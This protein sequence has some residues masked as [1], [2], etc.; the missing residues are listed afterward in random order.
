M[1]FFKPIAAF[2]AKVQW[3]F[4]FY[5][6]ESEFIT[7][8]YSMNAKDLTS[9]VLRSIQPLQFNGTAEELDNGLVAAM[10]APAVKNLELIHNLQTHQASVE[11]AK[12]TAE[13]EKEKSKGTTVSTGPT[14]KHV[15]KDPRAK[16][17]QA[18][19]DKVRELKNQKK[20][21]QA[22]AQLPKIADYPEKKAEITALANELRA[23]RGDMDLFDQASPGEVL[24]PEVTKMAT[25]LAP[26]EEDEDPGD[27]G[28]D[29]DPGSTEGSEESDE[30]EV[31]GEYDEEHSRAPSQLEMLEK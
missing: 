16:K 8:S 22:I 27:N 15:V 4:T 19:M 2:G 26:S 7:G 25:E 12:K 17:Y 5:V 3:T 29:G 11:L 24:D 14:S 30:G 20:Y 18:A 31:D 1:P 13:Q 6:D 9:K 21:G 28:Q 10:T 23:K